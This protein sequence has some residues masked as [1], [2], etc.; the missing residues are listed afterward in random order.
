MSK[1]LEKI[2]Q[3]WE[4]TLLVFV[5]LVML[6][7]FGVAAYFVLHE[8]EGAVAANTPLPKMPAYFDTDNTNFLNPAG[9][10]DGKKTAGRV[11]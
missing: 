3:E 4:R 10:T 9:M 1:P 6:A 8:Q 7:G 11:Q 5:L 2:T